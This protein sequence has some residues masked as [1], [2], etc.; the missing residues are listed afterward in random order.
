MN[1]IEICFGNSYT[2]HGEELVHALDGEFVPNHTLMWPDPADDSS[3]QRS[4]EPIVAR[5]NGV[6]GALG[7]F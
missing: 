2:T 1:D 4:R 6:V 5:I 7:V 3:G